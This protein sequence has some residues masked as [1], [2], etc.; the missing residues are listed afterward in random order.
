MAKRFRNKARKEVIHNQNTEFY[1]F[2]K[3]ALQVSYKNINHPERAYRFLAGN[4]D[5][6]N[7]DFINWYNVWL[8]NR[9]C[10]FSPNKALGL[11]SRICLFSEIIHQFPL[12]NKEINSEIAV[13]GYEIGAEFIKTYKNNRINFVWAEVQANLSIVYVDRIRGD[14]SENLERAILA[15]NVALTIVKRENYPHLWAALKNNLARAYCYRIDGDKSEN[16][17]RAINLFK[18]AL[19]IHT[20]ELFP[21]EW[22]KLQMN[23]GDT[24]LNR[25]KGDKSEN[26]DAALVYLSSALDVYTKDAF[27]ALWANSLN[28]LGAIFLQIIK[29]DH[30]ENL[31]MSI[32]CL[33]AALQVYQYEVYPYDWAKTNL[34]L[35][36][37][38]RDRI[39]GNSIDDLIISIGSY[40]AA[41]Q[42]YTKEPYSREWAITQ[43]NLGIAYLKFRYGNL[44][45]HQEKAREAFE[46]A[47]QVL[48]Q[49]IFPLDWAMA[50]KNLLIVYSERI[51]G[52][53]VE[54]LDKAIKAYTAASQVFTRDSFPYYWAKNQNNVAI[55]Y[56]NLGHIDKAIACFRL[57][58]EVFTPNAFPSECFTSGRQFGEIAAR[59]KNWS[60]AIEGFT[61]AVEAVET[62]RSWVNSESRRQ[63]ILEESIDVYQNMV[64]ACINAGQID[65]A[66]EYAE[67]SRSQRLVD[68]MAGFQLSQG[69][70]IPPKVQE[71]L[72]QYEELQQQIDQERQS[73]QS[74]NSRSETRAAWEAYNEVI[75]SL[76]I[77]KQQ[78]WEK[79]R[80][81]DPVLAGEIQVNPLSLSEI[82]QLIEQP[83]TAI[84]SFYT[85]NDDT[86]I[87]VVLKN[88]INLHTCAGEGLETLQGWISQNWLIPYKD[89]FKKWESQIESILHQLAERL[90]IS[91]LISQHLEGI[92]ELILVPHLLLHQIPFAALPTGEYQ[93]YLGDKFLIRYTPSCQILDFCHQ[94]DTVGIFPEMSLQYGTV[95]DAE[96]NLPCARF[97]GET[98][99]QMYNIPPENRL[100]GS[101]QA[102]YKNYRQLV[103]KV[104]VIHSCHHAQSRL[105]NPLESQLKLAPGDSITLGQ[106][107]TPSWR[108]PQLIEVFLSCCETNLGI[109]ALTDDLLT[110]STGFLC[111]GAR[112][113]ISSLWLVNDLATA[114]FSI[115]YYQQ[116]KLGKSRP[117]A[118]QQGQIQ[119]R[120][121]R[122]ADLKEIS[123]QVE[124]REKELIGNRK[125][126][127]SDSREC[128]EW[129]REYNLYAKF[130]RRIKEIENST[131]QFPFANPRYWAAFICHGLG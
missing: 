127:I 38:Y 35:A 96:D 36:N 100:I 48:S 66:V 3:E 119:L 97:E 57:S 53:K 103:Q 110:L 18:A 70:D 118:L 109:P 5:Y 101:S 83:N 106:L 46:A 90:Q 129:E 15:C 63:E 8:S 64:Q 1:F 84:L 112:S 93:E 45:E 58:L 55:A 27:P 43:N 73:R 85:T 77:E 11:C 17:E 16:L 99:A 105:D 23:L 51:I 123:Q 12:G 4:L 130:N 59:A 47:L 88:Q 121:L 56:T 49:E 67:R 62:S 40:Q 113:V 125:K 72:Q 7:D 126:Y 91:A 89:D 42:V 78:I 75:A 68:L 86:H 87:F 41:L 39:I 29:G 111:A 33:K 22:A 74:E 114:L 31:E 95:E 104:Q 80:R 25:V 82:Q 81:E 21:K 26:L 124:E 34:N 115:F 122:K 19:G 54:N 76:E 6:I 116:R 10:Q 50:Q 107:M 52:N 28:T 117:E 69:E 2:L 94:R 32:G 14:K 108:L 98:L 131:Q 24:Y 60:V 30:A 120:E 37:A 92:E 13:I 128:G 102:T 71:L 20:R 61:I 79:L 65:K 44:A 9:I